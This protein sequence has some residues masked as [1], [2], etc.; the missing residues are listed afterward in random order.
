MT[1]SLVGYQLVDQNE[2]IIQ[3]WGGIPGQYPS[4]PDTIL[5]PNGDQV[6]CP[7]IGILYESW[8]LKN[9]M[10]DSPVPAQNELISSLILAASQ[11]CEKIISYIY[12]DITHQAAFQNAASIINS[13]NGIAPSI[14]PLASKFN[15]LAAVYGMSPSIFASVVVAMQSASFDLSIAL[16]ILSTTSTNA[17]TSADLVTA[18]TIFESSITNVVNE[19]NSSSLPSKISLPSPIMIVGINA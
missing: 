18:L 2:E 14:D 15:A 6:H 4:I 13:N 8:T 7:E 5:L 17:L 10:M 3:S 1:Q 9:W 11:T 12:P 19:I 16:S